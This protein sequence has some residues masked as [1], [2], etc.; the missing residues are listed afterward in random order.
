MPFPAGLE[1]PDEDRQSALLKRGKGVAEIFLTGK[2]P[3]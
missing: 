2:I 1:G 3:M